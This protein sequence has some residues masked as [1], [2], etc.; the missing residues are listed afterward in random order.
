MN[1]DATSVWIEHAM[2]WVQS[3]GLTYYDTKKFKDYIDLITNAERN[4]CARL[5]EGLTGRSYEYD[6]SRMECCNAILQ[7]GKE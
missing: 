4:E 5:C 6:I 2:N 3:L 7:R 1:V